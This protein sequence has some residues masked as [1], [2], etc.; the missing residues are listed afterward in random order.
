MYNVLSN[1]LPNQPCVGDGWREIDGKEALVELETLTCT[2]I[3]VDST[4]DVLLIES[5]VTL[6]AVTEGLTS[7]MS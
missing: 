6:L 1:S 7:D 5:R 2:V 3:I 4:E